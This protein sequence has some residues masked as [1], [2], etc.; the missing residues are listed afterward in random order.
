[1]TTEVDIEW[2][3]DDEDALAITLMTDG[4]GGGDGCEILRY[5]IGETIKLLNRIRNSQNQNYIQLPLLVVA[6]LCS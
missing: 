1:M 5:G 6:N 3:N 2:D 4:G